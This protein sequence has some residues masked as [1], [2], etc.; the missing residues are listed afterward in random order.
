MNHHKLSDADERFLQPPADAALIFAG[1]SG[2][3]SWIERETD[4][5]VQIGVKS[6]AVALDDEATLQVAVVI[7]QDA[8]RGQDGPAPADSQLRA[9]QSVQVLVKAGQ[10]LALKAFPTASNAQVLRTVV[11]A[12]DLRPAGEA[13][14]RTERAGPPDYAGR[15]EH[16]AQR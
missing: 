3:E 12:A 4:T 2:T 14:A 11:W 1:A 10:R 7:G 9:S 13:P 16:Q 5:V 15:G 8:A 6:A